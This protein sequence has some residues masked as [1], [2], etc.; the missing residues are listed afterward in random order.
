MVPAWHSA[1]NAHIP[2][3]IYTHPPKGHVSAYLHG[4]PIHENYGPPSHE[5]FETGWANSGPGLGSE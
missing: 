1:E 4:A 5:H 3:I 2:E